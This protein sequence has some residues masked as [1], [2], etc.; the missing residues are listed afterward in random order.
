MKDKLSPHQENAIMDA[1]SNQGIVVDPDFPAPQGALP[2]WTKVFTRPGE[3]TFQEITS[4]P[5]AKAR[6]AYIWVFLA[7]TL[8]GLVS[9]LLQFLIAF[10][11]LQQAATQYGGLPGSS[12]LYGVSGLLFAIC[13]AP[14][15]GVFS[16][17]GFALSVAIV[18][19]TARFFEGQGDFDK[20]AYAF[21][22]V[23]APLTLVS[24]L[25]VPLNAIPFAVFCTLP[26]LLGLNIYGW[27]LQVAAVKAVHKLG[28]GESAAA[29]FLPI[30][31]LVLLCGV[32]VL[33]LMRAVGPSITEIMQQI[34]QGMPTP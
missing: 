3:Q 1:Q 22:A 11:G 15:T 26:V 14:L 19:A 7:G 25:T 5:D 9:S 4:H 2:V 18:H 31:L 21:G 24:L 13:S 8:S 30:V 12:G 29:F 23:A 34:Q 10:A 32:L 28:W 16:V 17:I 20:L 27:Y 33:V 6:A